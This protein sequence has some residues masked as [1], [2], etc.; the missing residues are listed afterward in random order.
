MYKVWEVRE[1]PGN[2]HYIYTNAM[3]RCPS[4]DK[5]Y[6]D[7]LRF[8]QTDGAALVEAADPADPYKTVVARSEDIAAAIPPEPAPAADQSDVLDLPAESDPNKTQFVSEEELR[9]EMAADEPVMEIPPAEQASEPGMPQP[10]Q[11]IEPSMVPAESAPPPSPFDSGARETP[12]SPPDESEFI[13]TTPPIP[14]PFGGPSVEKE[15]RAFESPEPETPQFTAHQPPSEAAFAEPPAPSFV[16][17]PFGPAA[18]ESDAEPPTAWT[19]PAAP[20]AEWGSAEIGQNTPFSPPAAGVEGPNKTLATVS[21]VLGILGILPCCGFLSG[22]PAVIVGFIA[23]SRAN[24]DPAN[25]GGGG[26]ATAGIIL[27]IV[28]TIIW[29]AILILQVVF[30]GIGGMLGNF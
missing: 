13:Q 1:S 3:K 27:G 8:C 2:F 29:G 7:N 10:P 15:M 18:G 24:N 21:L 5:T 16:A 28:G 25:Y 19:P 12:D 23:R 20:A 22:I 14:S 11:F 30:F 26:L 6:D 4:C 9:R 17:V